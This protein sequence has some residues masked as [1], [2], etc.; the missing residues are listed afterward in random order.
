MSRK[1]AQPSAWDGPAVFWPKLISPKKKPGPRPYIA[2]RL[3]RPKFVL[4]ALENG[5]TQEFLDTKSATADM[6]LAA[7]EIE[8]LHAAI[9]AQHLRLREISELSE[10]D[11]PPPNLRLR[12]DISKRMAR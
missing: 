10:A 11:R 9:H 12:N 3:R 4:V 8:W 6:T 7:E 2:A 5:K 1:R